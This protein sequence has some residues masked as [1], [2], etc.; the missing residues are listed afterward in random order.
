[1]KHSRYGA[2]ACRNAQVYKSVEGNTNEKATT[3]LQRRNK[4]TAGLTGEEY[5]HGQQQHAEQ[6][7]DDGG[8]LPRAPRH[9]TLAEVQRRGVVMRGGAAHG[10][11]RRQHRA[12]VAAVVALQRVFG[13]R[14][15]RRPALVFNRRS[16]VDIC[17]IHKANIN[18]E[19]NPHLCANC[20]CVCVKVRGRV[21]IE[22]VLAHSRMR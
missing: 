4:K 10:A 22:F 7:D 21:I 1:M 6:N 16:F 19:F 18:I 11:A 15:A 3:T 2:T 12:R 13:G 8:A 14:R 9:Q 17:G 5:Q 20:V